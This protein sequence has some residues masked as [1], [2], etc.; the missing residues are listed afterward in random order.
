MTPQLL[1]SIFGGT[2]IPPCSCLIPGPGHSRRDRSLSV[3]IDPGHPRGYLVDSKAGDP[4]QEC[5]DYIEAGLGRPGWKP[6][7]RRD[8]VERVRTPQQIE[9][10][11]QREEEADV[12][13]E[14]MFEAA[15]RTWAET[16]S[17]RGSL[18]EIYLRHR[19]GRDVPDAV[20]RGGHLRFHP[21]CV[22][23]LEDGPSGEKRTVRLPSMV[24]LM[25]DPVTGERRGIHRTALRLDGKGK[26]DHPELQGGQKR[27]LGYGKGA[28]IR[29]CADEEV[30]LGLGLSEGIENGLSA[31]VAGFR[32]VWAAGSADNMRR[33]PVLAGVEALTLF[34]DPKPDS[35]GRFPGRLAAEE[36]GQR[37]AD[38]GREAEA[39]YPTTADDWNDALRGAA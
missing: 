13:A 37:W 22:F 2:V 18:A 26:S 38:A 16:A 29:L 28:V 32:P 1:V 14:R 33:F 21:G 4:W 31:M 25:T 34:G 17:L 15:M 36:V 39:V 12:T 35:K 11:R 3:R 24:A 27:W 9:A 7:E 19:L 10:A 6:G 8:L 30:T 20:F 23:R 5:V